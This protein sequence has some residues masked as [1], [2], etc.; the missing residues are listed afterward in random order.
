MTPGLTVSPQPTRGPMRLRFTLPVAGHVDI[1]LYD[2]A[3]RRCLTL[4][5]GRYESGEHVVEGD[6]AR[7]DGGRPAAGIRFVR[8]AYEGRVVSRT[9]VVVP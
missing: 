2:L 5:E 6:L 1:S 7:A 8:L 3:G 9:V 4:A